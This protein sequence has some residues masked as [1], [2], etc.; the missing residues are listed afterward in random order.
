MA[1]EPTKRDRMRPCGVPSSSDDCG[2]VVP[3]FL[4]SSSIIHTCTK[5]ILL[6]LQWVLREGVIGFINE[7]IYTKK[8]RVWKN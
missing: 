4:W 1:L 3:S 6:F 7:N 2:G 8:M 5:Y